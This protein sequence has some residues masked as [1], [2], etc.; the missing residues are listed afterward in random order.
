MPL[1]A[2]AIALLFACSVRAQPAK[3]REDL[4]PPQIFHLEADAGNRYPDGAGRG[5]R[6]RP[7][8]GAAGS[9]GYGADWVLRWFS[10]GV[11]SEP[12]CS[13]FSL[14][15]ASDGHF[16][17]CRRFGVSCGCLNGGRLR[18]HAA[19]DQHSSDG[20]AEAGLVDTRRLA[21]LFYLQ[22]RSSHVTFTT[23]SAAFSPA[24]TEP[25]GGEY[26]IRSRGALAVRPDSLIYK[27][28]QRSAPCG[29]LARWRA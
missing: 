16:H 7:L 13:E 25:S 12:L 14:W 23:G 10:H 28:I 4:E 5:K 6:G 1:R 18:T 21:E 8:A 26:G 20:R 27:F 2:A 3:P 19:S 29:L 24:G 17:L 15:N 22:P 9:G 11:G